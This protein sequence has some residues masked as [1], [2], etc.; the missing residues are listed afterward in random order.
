MKCRA[1]AKLPA[2]CE[3]PVITI[4]NLTPNGPLLSIL[5]FIYSGFISAHW[6]KFEPEL[7]LTNV[8]VLIITHGFKIGPLQW[9][10]SGL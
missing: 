6:A 4:T 3:R 9:N 8:N 1:P 7:D 10:K 2:F 5:K